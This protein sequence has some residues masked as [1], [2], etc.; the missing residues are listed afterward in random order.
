MATQSRF[1]VNRKQFD[2]V[3]IEITVPAP[4]ADDLKPG[5]VLMKVDRF[6]FT[7]NNISYAATGE[8]F[9]YWNFFPAREGMGVIPVWGFADVLESRCE[10][11]SAG[12]RFY[13]YYP[14]ATHLLVEP[15][16]RSAA[17]F[18][19]GAEHRQPLSVIYNQYVRCSADPL[20]RADAEALQMLLRPLFTTSFLLDDFLE[21]NRFFGA[22][23]ILLTSA[24]SKTALGMAFCLHN[25]RAK[26]SSNYEIVGLTSENNRAFVEGLACY[27]SVLTYDQIEQLDA[28]CPSVSVDFAGNGEI[29]KRLH[30]HYGD[31][32]KHSCLV[33]AAHWDQRG[34]S[35]NELD[36]PAPILFFAPT[37]AEKRLQEWG[38]MQFQQR[39]A[40]QWH[41]FTE[42]VSGW[43][44]VSEGAGRDAVEQVYLEVLAGRFIPSTGHILSLWEN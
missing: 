24:S 3:R 31:R 20:Y 42:F 30:A 40:G 26:R 13:G 6:S 9:R 18:V 12:E 39:L 32:L 38:A 19:D 43:M 5:Q 37:Q 22:Q 34:G 25:N 41:H 4:R 17:G 14:M 11:I 8:S 35:R 36:G 15:T 10:G 28:D 1:L 44:S 27:D 29:L 21:D 2:N 16:V 7:A 33:G 23:T